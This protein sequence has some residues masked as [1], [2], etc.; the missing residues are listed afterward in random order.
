[1]ND[2]SYNPYDINDVPQIR[3]DKWDEMTPT[4]LAEQLS[5]MYDRLYILSNSNTTPGVVAQ[6]KQYIDIIKRKL[7][8][9]A[10]DTGF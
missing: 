10:N 5:I 8:G 1:M 7:E 9:C 3:P 6:F 4:E 2:D